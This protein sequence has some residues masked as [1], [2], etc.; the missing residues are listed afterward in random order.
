MICYGHAWRVS[1]ATEL[2]PLGIAASSLSLSFLSNVI[3]SMVVLQFF[4]ILQSMQS[5]W[6]LLRCYYAQSVLTVQ[7]FWRETA[8]AAVTSDQWLL[9]QWEV[10]KPGPTSHG[11]ANHS[12]QT[13]NK[14]KTWFLWCTLVA[15]FRKQ[16][17]FLRISRQDLFPK[18]IRYLCLV[19]CTWRV[20]FSQKSWTSTGSSLQHSMVKDNLGAARIINEMMKM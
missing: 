7:W 12:T 10:Q 18:K 9:D 3:F 17:E 2:Q 11:V 1:S 20:R 13:W 19:S 6:L 8:A 16:V 4:S 14:A 5:R 15:N